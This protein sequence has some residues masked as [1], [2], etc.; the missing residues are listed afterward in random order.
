[1]RN[2]TPDARRRL[3]RRTQKKKYLA[4]KRA[5]PGSSVDG[6]AEGSSS[7][8][9][10][11]QPPVVQ[12]S[13]CEPEPSGGDQEDR[14]NMRSRYH[15]FNHKPFIKD[16]PGCIA[17]SRGKK[18]MQGSFNAADP[19]HANTITLDQMTL[20]DFDSLNYTIKILQR[21]FITKVG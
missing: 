11:V 20:E 10:S 3:K 6:P 12:C 9:S 19:K 14:R 1:M 7:S 15:L 2:I 18:H 5:L 8:S 4:F 13:P 16:C 21:P 17:K